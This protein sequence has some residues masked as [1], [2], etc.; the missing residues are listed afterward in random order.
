MQRQSLEQ[1][2]FND[3]STRNLITASY[4]YYFFLLCYIFVVVG[5]DIP[6]EVNLLA[7]T[8]SHWS[9]QLS[10]S[11]L[12]G[13]ASTFDLIVLRTEFNE[14]VFYVSGPFIFV[15][16]ASLLFSLCTLL[17]IAVRFIH[18]S[19]LCPFVIK[20]HGSLTLGSKNCWS[21]NTKYIFVMSYR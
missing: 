11:W 12:G 6:Q 20:S 13:T 9:Q 8:D 2:D 10:I 15:Y 3:N 19:F 21:N 7:N 14:T 1:C 5:L 4:Y 17:L 16:F 18:M